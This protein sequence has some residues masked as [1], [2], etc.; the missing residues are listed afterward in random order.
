MNETFQCTLFLALYRYTMSAIVDPS[1]CVQDHIL[2]APVCDVQVHALP[3]AMHTRPTITLH[4]FI[5]S[6][7]SDS[8]ARRQ[9]EV[10]ITLISTHRLFIPEDAAALEEDLEQV[11]T[12]FHAD[13]DGLPCPE[14]V[15]LCGALSALLDVM[16]LDTGILIAN[17]EQVCLPGL[18]VQLPG[19]SFLQQGWQLGKMVSVLAWYCSLCTTPSQ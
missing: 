12:L 18:H 3:S 13:G 17:Y 6:L 10:R 5:S 19:M 15:Q 16:A 11:Q 9:T 4:A 7:Q 8:I 2:L 14:I 1:N